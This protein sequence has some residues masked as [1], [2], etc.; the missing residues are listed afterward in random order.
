MQQAA[1]DDLIFRVDV[2]RNVACKHVQSD[3]GDERKVDPQK[4]GSLP[5]L[6]LADKEEYKSNGEE[7]EDQNCDDEGLQEVI[8]CASHFIHC[9]KKKSGFSLG[10]R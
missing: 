4:W 5:A 6:N 9:Y 8:K 2:M 3:D 10:G 1:F 7:E